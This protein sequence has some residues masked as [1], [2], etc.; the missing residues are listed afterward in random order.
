M[1]VLMASEGYQDMTPTG[2]TD[3][4]KGR[5]YACDDCGRTYWTAWGNARRHTCDG[6]GGGEV[7]ADGGEDPVPLDDALREAGVQESELDATRERV[8]DALCD[9]PR[10]PITLRESAFATV[11]AVEVCDGA[12]GHACDRSSPVL[13]RGEDEIHVTNYASAPDRSGRRVLC[14]ECKDRQTALNIAEMP[15]LAKMYREELPDLRERF[16]SIL[17]DVETD[18]EPGGV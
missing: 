13:I 3:G 15:D 10:M 16:P 5:E 2:R 1:V 8:Q 18:G 9:S 6:E 12:D 4:S 11:D 7:R 17:A 14:G